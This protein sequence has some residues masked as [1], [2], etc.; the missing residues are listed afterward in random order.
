MEQTANKYKAQRARLGV[1][2][3]ISSVAVFLLIGYFAARQL[4]E[5][6][7]IYL[8]AYRDVSVS[9][10]EVGSP[11]RYLGI[12]VGTISDIFIDPKD[13]NNVIVRISLEAGTPVKE[14]AVA[15]IVA[16]GITGLRTIEIRGGTNEAEFLRPNQYIQPGTSL[17]DDISGRAE[18]IAFKAEEVLNNLLAFTS[19]ENMEKF[20][21][22]AHNISVLAQ[23]ADQTILLIDQTLQENRTDI[24]QTVESV[25]ALA[26]MLELT[27]QELYLATGRFNELMHGDTLGNILGNL[28]DITSSVKESNIEELIANLSST[29]AQ[30][31]ILI[32]RLNTEFERGT[33]GFSENLVLLEQVLGNLNEASRMIS[34]DPSVLLRGHRARNIPDRQLQE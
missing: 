33:Q 4:F 18:V 10:L 1:F 13:I 14:D 27:S 8:I 30:T 9:G 17:V 15:D 3:F 26:Q 16:I 5:R 23:N 12:N 25:S 31:K 32:S 20:S 28:Q 29:V 6:K 2:I 21:E 19:D 22:A 7:D 34:S 24:R 11:V